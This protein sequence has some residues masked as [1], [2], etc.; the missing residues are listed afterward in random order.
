MLYIRVDM[1]KEIATG[2]LMRCVS[3]ADAARA[4]GEETTFLLADGEAEAYLSEKGYRYVVLRTDWRDMEGELPAL[5]PILAAEGAKRL[6]IDSYQVTESYLRRLREK[7][8]TVYLDDL[9]RFV[10]PV[11]A[12]ICYAVY[13]KKFRYAEGYPDT[14]RLYLGTR[15]VPLRREF[16]ALNAKPIRKRMLRVLA[17]SGGADPYRASE[18]IAE[19]LEKIGGLEMDVVCGRYSG[20]YERLAERYR[21]Q[22]WARIYR[23][24]ERMADLMRGADLAISA[25]GSTLY[26]LCACGVP[27]ISYVL[28]DN[29]IENVNQFQRDGVIDCAGDI[30]YGSIADKL[31]ELLAQYGS[32]ALRVKRSALMRS[33]VDGGGARR[34]A[35]ILR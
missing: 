27:T 29:Q 15:Y 8:E 25:G 13:W 24:T 34:I 26:E 10:Y 33:V 6:L 14:T 7:V 28:A 4:M 20:S 9:N 19:A 18:Q 2:H 17:L 30:R 35:Q 32:Q 16:S 1:N 11:D 31:Q 5:F 3:I 22:S 21:G 12:L 23:S